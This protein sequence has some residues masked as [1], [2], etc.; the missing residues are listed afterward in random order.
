MGRWGTP[1]PVRDAGRWKWEGGSGALDSYRVLGPF[2]PCFMN[3]APSFRKKNW[4]T[5][6]VH[7]FFLQM[8]P[9]AGN[10][11]GE[12]PMMKLRNRVGSTC[13]SIMPY[14]KESLY[15]HEVID[16]RLSDEEQRRRLL[17]Q[18]GQ[19]RTKPHGTLY[20]TW[21]KHHHQDGILEK[22]ASNSKSR[23]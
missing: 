12:G 19:P 18:E 20:E 5:P 14:N 23:D 8:A 10:T 1:A 21:G 3:W 13:E 16:V 2:L 7:G 11:P 9:C 15:I 22:K 4:G 17:A 6:T